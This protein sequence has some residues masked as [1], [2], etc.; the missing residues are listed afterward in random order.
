MDKDVMNTANIW[1]KRVTKIFLVILMVCFFFPFCT[2]SCSD[3]GQEVTGLDAAMGMVI[4]LGEMDSFM[5]GEEKVEGN[6]LFGLLFVLPVIMLVSILAIKE[7][8]TISSI[9]LLIGGGIDI[10]LLQL[11]KQE[12][13]KYVETEMEGL[14][15]ISYE[16]AYHLE[17]A[18]NILLVVAGVLLLVCKTKKTERD[19]GSI[20]LDKRHESR[21]KPMEKEAEK[22]FK[23][24]VE[25]SEVTEIKEEVIENAKKEMLSDEVEK[26]ESGSK[27]KMT[28][29]KAASEGSEYG[30]NKAGDL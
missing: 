12:V 25:M 6:L 5:T 29:R 14:G 26:A 3:V 11:F 16:P 13:T 23:T 17:I 27:L 8:N 2:V 10:V 9:I 1:I 4:D 15:S 18:L 28:I 20:P 30:F 24:S 21:V 7:K 22:I 19:K